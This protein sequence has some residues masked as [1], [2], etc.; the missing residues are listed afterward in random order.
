MDR[1]VVELGYF[2]LSVEDLE[3]ARDFFSQLFNWEFDTKPGNNYSHVKNAS[4]PFGF[5]SGKAQDASNLYFRVNSIE[6]FVKK[7]EK[8][9]GKAHPILQSESGLSCICLDNQGTRFGLWQP[10]SGF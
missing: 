1:T 6:E 9:G 4:L 3:K 8:L 2:T 10:A 5:T 7:I